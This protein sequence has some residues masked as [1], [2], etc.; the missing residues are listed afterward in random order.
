MTA[1]YARNRGTKKSYGYGWHI[2]IIHE[3]GERWRFY[4]QNTLHHTLQERMCRAVADAI[5]SRAEMEDGD[6]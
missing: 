1:E 3:S 4:P 5:N 6:G 2:D